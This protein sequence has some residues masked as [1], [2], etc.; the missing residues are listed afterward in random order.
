MYYLG[1]DIGTTTVCGVVTDE[2]GNSVFV[3]TLKNNSS[4]SPAQQNADIIFQLVQTLYAAT[5]EK[6]SVTA[7]GI[8]NQMHGVVY[9]DQNGNAVSPLFTWQEKCGDLPYNKTET[10]AQRLS[11][12]LGQKVFSGYGLVTHFYLSENGLLPKNAV[13]FCSVGDY[14]AMRLCNQKQ[15]LVH[16]SNSASFGG[17]N[18]CANDFCKNAKM[19]FNAYLPPICTRPSIVGHT[20]ENIPVLCAIGDNQAS[21]YACL[22]NTEDVVLNVGTGSQISAVVQDYPEIAATDL[23]VRPFIENDYL[24]AGSALCGGKAFALYIRFLKDVFSLYNVTPPNDLYT[25]FFNALQQSQTG[26][27]QADTRFNGTRSQPLI[28]GSFTEITQENFSPLPFG[29]GVIEGIANELFF[30]Y[31]QFPNAVKLRKNKIVFSGNGIRLNPYLQ[32]YCKQLF[33]KNLLAA[34]I[35]EECA[36]GACKIAAK[37]V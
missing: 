16:I 27:V 14:V 34:K 10:Y 12:L 8:S 23:E 1:I 5:M 9:Y 28:T 36:Y 15:P 6:Y 35:K 29:K 32:K 18:L 20:Q 4:I 7:V 3:R 22:E 31:Q 21:V 19:L 13:G 33:G 25:P 2:Q 17:F 11:R 24:L 26:S 37:Y 30:Y